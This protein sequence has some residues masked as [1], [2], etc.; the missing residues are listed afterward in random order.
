M[1]L[2]ND[3]WTRGNSFC[4]MFVIK[5]VLGRSHY[6]SLGV[7][8]AHKDGNSRG[9]EGETGG[10]LPGVRRV[11]M[12]TMASLINEGT[13]GTIR[14]IICWDQE[15]YIF[16]CSVPDE[17]SIRHYLS[18]PVLG[19]EHTRKWI[20]G[21][22]YWHRLVARVISSQS[23]SNVTMWVT[24]LVMLVTSRNLSQLK[25]FACSGLPHLMSL[26]PCHVCHSWHV[27]R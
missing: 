18:L 7:K 2:T 4:W 8:A 9:A 20:S 5:S 22:G 25:Q 23:S 3:T 1:H 13:F 10:V 21:A 12:S 14:T 15:N 17:V 6:S 19:W 27:T 16:H 26:G 24:L 11:I